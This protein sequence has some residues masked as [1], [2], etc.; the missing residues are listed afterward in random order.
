MTT[1]EKMLDLSKQKGL[2]Q[3]IDNYKAEMIEQLAGLVAIPSLATDMSDEGMPIGPEIVHALHH[4][5][6]LSEKLGF[7]TH[8]EDDKYG[9]AEVGD[10]GPLVCIFTHLDIVPVGDGWTKEP[11]K[12]TEENGRL[13]GRGALD[14]KGPAIASLYGVKA[15]CDMGVKWPCRVR[16][17]FGTN[18]EC[19]M[20]DVQMYI[21]KYGAPDFSFVPDSQF[22][23]S[24]SELGTTTFNIRKLYNPAEV[25]ANLPVRLVRFESTEHTNCTPSAAM[26]VLQA[27]NAKLAEQIAVQAAEFAEKNQVNMTVTVD[28]CLVEMN[29]TGV[30][31]VHWNE[32][33]TATN[34]LLQ[35]TQ[36]LATISLGEEPDQLIRFV[37]QKIGQETDG[38]SLGI[39]ATTETA[40]L[41]VATSNVKIDQHGMN[42]EFFMIAPAEVRVEVLIDTILRQI[43]KDGMELSIESMGPGMLLDKQMP[44]LKTLYRSYSEV[45]GMS[46]PIK[47]CGGTYSKFIPN[48]VPFGAIFTEET[49]ICHVPDEWIYVS[50]FMIWAKIYSNA[51]LRICDELI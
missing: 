25:Q 36:F 51:V 31:S 11:F 43:R 8:N 5:L 37:A 23:L 40:S 50:D 29:V 48:A 46:E 42:F 2:E 6:E 39:K 27:E 16:I 21:H 15:C 28:D 14:N 44:L 47:V 22:P 19:G 12:L 7:R 24:Y 30:I 26:A 33:W 34:P 49:D 38:A 17:W 41:S 3:I 4:A 10:E 45:S 9:W 20:N 32:P 35:L 18:E 1:R 13:Y